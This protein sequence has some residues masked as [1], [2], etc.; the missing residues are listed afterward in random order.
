MTAEIQAVGN[1]WGGMQFF[2]FL[3]RIFKLSL[4]FISIAK[5]EEHKNAITTTKRGLATIIN[6]NSEQR[7]VWE[8]AKKVG[9][10]SAL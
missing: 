3:I 2:C 10:L 9:A 1:S 4:S 8:R 7:K 6:C 5:L